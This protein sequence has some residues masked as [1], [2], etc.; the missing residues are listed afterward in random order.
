M[1]SFEISTCT[2][3]LACHRFKFL[4]FSRQ[5]MNYFLRYPGIKKEK[6]RSK[7]DS[8][9]LVSL[10]SALIFTNVSSKNWPIR[11]SKFDL[12]IF[13]FISKY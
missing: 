5:F 3:L 2:L 8:C 11:F 7:K 1:V 9:A 6:D 12:E 4:K 13:F 10:G